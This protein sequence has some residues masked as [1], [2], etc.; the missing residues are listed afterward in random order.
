MVVGLDGKLRARVATDPLVRDANGQLRIVSLAINPLNEREW[1]AAARGLGL[2]RSSDAGVT[3]K[4]FTFNREVSIVACAGGKTRA[5]L[6]ATGND[7]VIIDLSRPLAGAQDLFPLTLA[8][9][10]ARPAGQSR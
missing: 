3:W 9:T 4:G 1:Y 10:I 8:E 5:T 2:I 7:T 6:I